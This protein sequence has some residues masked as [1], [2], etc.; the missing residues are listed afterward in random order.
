RRGRGLRGRGGRAG[1]PGRRPA[2]LSS[3]F[4]RPAT[5]PC[6]PGA[7]GVGASPGARPG[8]GTP[9]RADPAPTGAPGQNPQSFM[10]RQRMLVGDDKT[11][12]ITEYATKEGDT[13]STTGH[14]AH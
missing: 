7:G 5:R 3:G 12:T 8:R 13:G 10:E 4:R 11:K 1:R 2:L 9:G 14:A 6:Y